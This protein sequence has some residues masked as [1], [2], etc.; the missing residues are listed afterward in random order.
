MRSS[1][2]VGSASRRY[3]SIR[4]DNAPRKASLRKYDAQG[5]R[6]NL[7]TVVPTPLGSLHSLKISRMASDSF[8]FV[9]EFLRYHT[10]MANAYENSK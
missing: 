2:D 1:A 5:N 7:P 10:Y 8:Q 4:K 6:I 9:G 3:L